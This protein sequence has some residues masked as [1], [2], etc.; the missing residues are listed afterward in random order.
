MRNGW[1][2]LILGVFGCQGPLTLPVVERLEPEGQNTV[3]QSWL[4]MLSPPERLERSLLLDV[5]VTNYFYE[6]GVDRLNLTSEKDVWGGRVVMTVYYDRAH[7]TFDNFTVAY[8]DAQ[9]HER[10]RER[11]T[12]EE[13]KDRA[14]GLFAPTSEPSTRPA[15]TAAE[16]EQQRKADEEM[17]AR[18][19]R[20]ILIKT[21]TRPAGQ[22]IDESEIAPR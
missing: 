10:R 8:I 17:A 18:L 20:Q 16:I 4:N 13:V 15:V 3:D 2:L 12:F 19:A 9:G 7:P 1:I 14:A 11:Y 22:P 6:R 5:L 21:A